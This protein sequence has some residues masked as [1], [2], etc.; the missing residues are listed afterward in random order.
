VIL[1]LLETREEATAAAAAPAGEVTV[2]YGRLIVPLRADASE[3]DIAAAQ[4]EAEQA[5]RALRSCADVAARARDY[6]R[7]SGVAGPVPLASLP[8][9]ER[10]V[11]ATLPAGRASAPVRSGTGIAVLFLCE[12]AGTAAAADPG[13][14]EAVRS[15]L[16]AERMV[17]YATGYLQ[18]LRRDAVVEY[19]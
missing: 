9:E 14:I 17:S 16:I 7:G 3:T 12:R 19:R 6:G 18:E 1:K 5:G 15:R 10:A 2:T 8:E 13:S 4:V 11:L